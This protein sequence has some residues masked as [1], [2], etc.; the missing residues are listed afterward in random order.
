MMIGGLILLRSQHCR[1]LKRQNSSVT[2]TQ[3]EILRLYDKRPRPK[4]LPKK[5]EGF[6]P[7]ILPPPQL[8]SIGGGKKCPSANMGGSPPAPL[9]RRPCGR[10]QYRV[11]TR[12]YPIFCNNQTLLCH[13]WQNFGGLP[14]LFRRAPPLG[15]RQSYNRS[16]LPEFSIV[17]LRVT[18][19]NFFEN[20][21]VSTNLESK[22][23]SRLFPLPVVNIFSKNYL[24]IY[25]I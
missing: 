22:Y 14:Q 7:K 15:A 1:D 2:L 23:D 4:I 3:K 8:R 5:F 19:L 11:S 25:H 12:I 16:V 9:I 20:G 18:F 6:A 24:D 17:L 10:P 13:L 21:G